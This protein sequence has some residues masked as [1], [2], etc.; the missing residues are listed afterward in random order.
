LYLCKTGGS[1]ASFAG[2]RFYVE[3]LPKLLHHEDVA[4]QRFFFCYGAQDMLN[5]PIIS[6]QFLAAYEPKERISGRE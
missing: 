1:S 4:D 5:T 2:L 3:N 6:F